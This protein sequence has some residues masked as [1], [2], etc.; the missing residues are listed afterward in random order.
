MIRSL[1]LAVF[2]VLVV[3]ILRAEADDRDVRDARLVTQARK[4][5]ACSDSG[6]VTFLM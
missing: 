4:S 6:L 2:L 5:V 3:A 1:S